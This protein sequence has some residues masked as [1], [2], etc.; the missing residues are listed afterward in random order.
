MNSQDAENQFPIAKVCRGRLE[1]DRKRE[2]S[3]ERGVERTSDEV[4]VVF[5]KWA[6]LSNDHDADD[7]HH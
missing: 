5:P 4:R 2:E 1:L 7:G 3:T 6:R